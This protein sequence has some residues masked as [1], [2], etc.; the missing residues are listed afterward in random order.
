MKSQAVCNLSIIPLR[1]EPSHR[2]EQ[3]SQ[4]LF[5]EYFTVL[6]EREEWIMIKGADPAYEGWIQRGQFALIDESASE[7][8]IVHVDGA[9]AQIGS[10]N[11]FPLLHGCVVPRAD[12]LVLNGELCRIEGS[13]RQPTLHDFDVEFPKLINYYLGAP[14]LWGGRSRFGVDCSGLMQLI[15]RHF[16]ISLHRDASDQATQGEIVDFL[17]EAKTGDLAFFDNEEGRI[18]HVGILLNKETI[19]HA[20]AHVRI[21]RIDTTGIYH[22]QHQSYTHRLRII[23][24]MITGDLLKAEAPAE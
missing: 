19:L 17:Q 20:S 6:E 16:A 12:E 10:Q 18:T 1:A 5:G 11:P 22:S 24:R 2:S 13:F 7:F 21:D 15:Y 3:V 8:E 4:L 23:K 9:T 14:Y